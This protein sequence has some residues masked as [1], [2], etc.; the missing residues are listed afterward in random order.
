ME[1]A[2]MGNINVDYLTGEATFEKPQGFELNKVRKL[3]ESLGYSVAEESKDAQHQSHD[4]SKSLERKFWICL[5]FTL[6]LLFH[7]FI[8]WAPLHD[9]YVQLC[10]A[11]PVFIIGLLHF[12]KSAW[13]SVMAGS[14]NMDVLIF[15]GSTSA[16]LYSL[17]GMLLFDQ[18]AP[19]HSTVQ[20]YLFFETAATIITLVLLGNL[21]EARS[22][23]Q[24]TN[25]IRELSAL[26]E[27]SAKKILLENGQEKIAVILAKHVLKGD[28][29]LVNTGDKIPVDGKIIKGEG[30]AD[31]SM[32]SGESA[33]VEKRSGSEITGGTLLLNGSFTMSAEKVGK[34]TFLSQV[35]EMVKSAQQKRPAIQKLGDKVSAIF[36]PIVL[37]ISALTF[38][39]TFFVLDKGVATSMMPAIAVLVISCPCAMGLATPT[40]VMVG[41]GRAARK[42]IL[43]KGG[44]ALETFSKIEVVVFDKTG[45]LTTGNIKPGK[46]S[47]YNGGQEQDALDILYSLE[48]F[49]SHPIAVSMVRALEGKTKAVALTNITE[50]KGVGISAKNTDGTLLRAGSFR[51]IHNK[52]GSAEHDVYIFKGDLLIAGLNLIDEIRESAAELISILKQNGI[53]TVMLSGDRNYKCEEVAKKLGIDEFH[54]E[55]LPAEKLTLIEELGKTFKVAMVGDGVN[56]SPALARADVG[57]SLGSGTQVAIGAAEIV[58]LGDGDLKKLDLARRISKHTMITIRQNL[59]WAFFYNVVAIPFA[60]AGFLNPMIGAFSM[61]FSDV[62]IIGNSIRLRSKKLR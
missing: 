50:E 61:A 43:V 30:Q 25:A 7:M 44:D 35:I 29:L 24:T 31:E 14:P 42:G 36:V 19:S 6:P 26:Q 28:I 32:I 54:A 60:A 57:I 12:G 47:L 9:P 3:I 37:A 53:R 21:I 13:G 27:V 45:T 40:A 51:M 18:I 39:V 56:D 55:K 1:K 11:I 20:S 52:D 10:L 49:S 4:H 33:P 2:G 59:F 41:L 22:V 48:R 23:K 46:I 16:F 8:H 38:L 58:L 17:I 5:V 15:I 62:I 34:D